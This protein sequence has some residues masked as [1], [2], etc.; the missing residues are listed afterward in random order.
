M[1]IFNSKSLNG[2]QAQ[3]DL[4]SNQRLKSISN[5]DLNLKQN[6]DFGKNDINRRMCYISSKLSGR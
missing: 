3:Y 1:R 6:F 5:N 2:I 4:V